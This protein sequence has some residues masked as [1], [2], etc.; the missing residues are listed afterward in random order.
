MARFFFL[1]FF[2]GVVA[3]CSPQILVI[4]DS[5]VK[6]F[7]GIPY[8]CIGHL[9]P[10]TMHRVGRDGFDLKE[11]L[12]LGIRDRSIVVY[13]FGEIDVRCHIG[14]QRDEHQRDEEEVL[15]TL[16]RRYL[17]A[18]V[19]N[20]SHFHDL[21][22]IVYNIVPPTDN[23]PNPDYPLYGSVEQR[24]RIAKRLNEILFS[25]CSEFGV[26]F[27]SI[28]D[29]YCDRNGVLRLDLSDGTIHIHPSYNQPIQQRL[30][31]LIEGER[32]THLYRHGRFQR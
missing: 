16:A 27:L 18:I 13:V 19:Q 3:F 5:H 28:Y 17:S 8:C 21:T 24:A 32:P 31:Q 30:F 20:R 26:L 29:Y 15:H 10:R 9:G 14:R 7:E 12:H 6:A 25:L 2:W 11:L 4:G 22:Q 23:T 1:F